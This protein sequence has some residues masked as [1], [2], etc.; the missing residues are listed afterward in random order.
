MRY[1]RN[2]GLFICKLLRTWSYLTKNNYVGMVV[3]VGGSTY[4]L[5]EILK[6]HQTLLALLFFQPVFINFS[7]LN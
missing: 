2:E 1:S 3:R 7:C 4:Y 5:I 6:V